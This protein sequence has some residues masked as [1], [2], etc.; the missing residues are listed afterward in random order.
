MLDDRDPAV[1]GIDHDFPVVIADVIGI[2]GFAEAQGVIGARVVISAV[3]GC[4]P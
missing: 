4:T 2:E 1:G 3:H